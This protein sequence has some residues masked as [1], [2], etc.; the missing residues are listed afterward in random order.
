LHI[1]SAA[2]D[3]MH[4]GMVD[5]LAGSLPVIDADIEAEYRTIPSEDLCPHFVH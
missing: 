3:Q 5:R 4:M 2:R 1:T